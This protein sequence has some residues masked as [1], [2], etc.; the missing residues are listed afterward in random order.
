[1]KILIDIG[2]PAHVHLFKNLAWELQRNGNTVYFTTRDKEFT[3]QLLEKYCFNY[4]IIGT[5]RKSLLSKII[6][7]FSI[8]I[9]L[10]IVGFKFKPDIT[11]S[12]GSFYLS[13]I[14]FLLRKPH[15]SLENNGNIEQVLLYKPFTQ[16][17]ITSILLNQDYKKKHIRIN[18]I[19]E[20][21]YLSPKYFIPNPNILK[22]L[23]VKENE[24]FVTIRLVSWNATHDVGVSNIVNRDELF[25]FISELSRKIKIFISSETALP[26]EL[27]KYEINL[28]PE[29]IHDVLY[30]S[31]FYVGEG[32][33]M[34]SEAACLGTYSVYINPIKRE[35]IDELK[36]YDLLY[37]TTDITKIIEITNELV[38]CC[39]KIELKKNLTDF[40]ADKIDFN[41]FLLW[42][43]GNY[44]DSFRIMQENSDYQYNFV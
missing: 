18:A 2:H 43:I 5:N 31:L 21:M 42:F 29:M 20:S 35:Y 41:Q 26:N 44:P 37:Q 39:K 36:K 13:F 15:I 23:G 4:S 14:S 24:N 38:H 11:L 9:Y 16:V 7:S 33:T 22:Q 25:S 1:M 27:K 10:L 8:V 12:H 19:H 3:I 28:S 6:S 30:Y 40:Y 17:I 34:A 32:A